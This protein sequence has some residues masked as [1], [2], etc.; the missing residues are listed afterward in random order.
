[1]SKHFFYSKIVTRNVITDF[2]Q[3]I[4]N[5]LGLDLL[6]YN[7]AINKTVNELF[8]QLNQEIKWYKIDIEQIGKGFLVAI[9]GDYK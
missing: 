4:R 1:M 7:E 6:S 2:V 8:E 3:G 5:F 9:Y